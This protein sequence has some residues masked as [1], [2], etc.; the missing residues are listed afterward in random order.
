MHNIEI[1]TP[2]I[3]LGKF[4]KLINCASTG[5]HTKLLLAENKVK[6]DGVDEVR[7]GRKLYPSNVIT[8]IGF[9]SFR[10]IKPPER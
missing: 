10:I 2:Y 1:S 6:V 5:G 8:I 9:G 7:R 4:L 3:T